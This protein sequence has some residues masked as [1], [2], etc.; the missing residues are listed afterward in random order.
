M[1]HQS[2]WVWAWCGPAL[3]AELVAVGLSYMNETVLDRSLAWRHLADSN[4]DWGQGEAAAA[5]WR[6]RTPGGVVDPDWPVA[7]PMLVSG[8][9]LTG[10]LRDPK[11][12]ACVRHSAEPT[13]V[14]A[15][16]YFEFELGEAALEACGQQGLLAP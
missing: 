11:Y 12:F 8:N 10:V 2:S 1:P 3:G 4:L 5:D 9:V 15:G 14:V 16:S 7:G 13:G 6:V